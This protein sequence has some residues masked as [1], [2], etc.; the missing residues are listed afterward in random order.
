MF[1][2]FYLFINK[3]S[4]VLQLTTKLKPTL[5]TAVLNNFY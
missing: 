2:A 1:T 3:D 5:R 4:T